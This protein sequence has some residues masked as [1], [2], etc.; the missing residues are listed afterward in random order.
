MALAWNTRQLLSAEPKG[1]PVASTP[2]EFHFVSRR[3]LYD[4]TIST[5][6]RHHS[7]AGE[8]VVLGD[9]HWYS[10]AVITRP[11]YALPQ[12]L[13]LS[14]DCFSKSETIGNGAIVGAPID[15]V[16]IEFVTLLSLLVREPLMPLGVRRIDGRPVKLDH[17]S[18]RISR[19]SPPEKI[20]PKGVNSVELRA[21]L[22]GLS[23][24][25]ERD[26][27]AIL[28]ASRL[29]HAALSLSVYDISTAYFSLVS[30][31]ECLSG[32]HFEGR[33]FNFDD[34]EKFKKAGDVIR[35][36]APLSANGDLV[37]ILKSALLDAEHFVWQKF[38]DFVEEFL[39]DEFWK[40]DELHPNGYLMPAI[41][42]AALRRF[43][44]EVYSAR[45]EFAH[46]GAPFPA[47]V[48]SGVTNRVSSRAMMEGMALVN[49]TRFVP[50]FVW[51]ERLTHLVLR[52]YL[53]RVIAPELAEDRARQIRE[54]IKLLEVIK[55]LPERARESLERLTHWTANFVDVA[56]V[57]PMAPNNEWALDE[58]SIQSL[59]AAGLIDG[60]SRSMN[61]K[62]W[63]KNREVG[64]I[65]GEFFFGADQNPLR[66]NTVLGRQSR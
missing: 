28:A 58:A 23:K 40:P 17:V 27:N 2:V 11:V 53:F 12:E 36:I 24:A 37:D 59:L 45:S 42:R 15:E 19:P 57:N 50:V 65:V 26:A 47:H 44:R 64:E 30:A 32:H 41:E 20:P 39:P 16:A 18:G 56:I 14:F 4:N 38:R 3:E 22:C 10:V 9:H 52:E 55:G 1:E 60:E 5:A 54:K 34:V 8:W 7:S 43:L 31:I 25:Q 62:S 33:R 29:Y 49:S 13:C 63:I 61:G 6:D 66:G 35:L 21:I 51:F 46:T 48:Q